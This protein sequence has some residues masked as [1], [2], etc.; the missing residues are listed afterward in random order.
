[1]NEIDLAEM[2][3]TV[4]SKETAMNA[5]KDSYEQSKGATANAKDSFDDAKEDFERA[6]LAL[7]TALHDGDHKDMVLE[8]VNFRPGWS[9]GTLKIDEKGVPDD[10]VTV[11][12]KTV[13]TVN[14]DAIKAKL[15]AGEELNYASL[16]KKR[17]LTLTAKRNAAD[18][19]RNNAP[20][21]ED[22]MSD[23]A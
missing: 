14:K 15:N 10:L 1:M 5:A 9:S 22:F 12:T 18:G 6:K 20:S 21:Y 11:T 7:A 17:T 16:V 8:G 19:I 2:A 13:R 4:L 3:R 23:G